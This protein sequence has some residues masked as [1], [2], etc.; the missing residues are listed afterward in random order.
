MEKTTRTVLLIEP[1]HKGGWEP[2]PWGVL[3]LGS[4]L[5]SRG[6]AVRLLCG[7]YLSAKQ[8]DE[9]L[10]RELPEADLVGI[11]CFTT[12][13][14]WVKDLVDRIK[15]ARPE[16]P[17]ILGGPHAILRPEQ[18]ATH[19]LIDFVAYGTGEETCLDLLHELR[20]GRRDFASV[21]GLIYRDNGTLRRTA[22]PAPP[23]DYA[24]DYELL[25]AQKRQTFS[26]YVEILAGRGCS[27]SCAFCYNAICGFKWR[28]KPAETLMDEVQAVVERYHP[29]LIYFRDENFFH[30]RSRIRR[31][32]D[33]YR[34]RGFS[35]K[36]RATCRANYFS[37]N[38][39][40]EDLLQAG[41]HSLRGTAFW[42]GIRIAARP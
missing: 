25:P 8:F 4:F 22:Q 28:G 14:A 13:A 32:I 41:I 11:A 26:R 10:R 15:A 42:N 1:D 23:P 36:W 16:T 34:E 12:D 40:N 20:S 31:F 3:A 17:I 19:P 29:E 7:S 39:I 33:L 35:F 18:T 2:F 21:P 37:E 38:Y 24:I 30:S 9:E 6:V 5:R 27:F